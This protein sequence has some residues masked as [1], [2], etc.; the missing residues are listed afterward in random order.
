VIHPA[1]RYPHPEKLQPTLHYELLLDAQ[2][3]DTPAADQLALRLDH[4]LRANPQ[5]AHARDLGQLGALS[6][7]RIDLLAARLQALSLAR[8]Q[9][10]GDAKPAVLGRIDDPD[11][12]QLAL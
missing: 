7:R 10:L 2:A 11:L 1:S 4:A 9:R 12:A 5:Y 8:G 6:A 3:V